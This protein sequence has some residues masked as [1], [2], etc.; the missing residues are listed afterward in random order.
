MLSLQ[1]K[2]P[3]RCANETRELLVS[4]HL[5]TVSDT[6]PGSEPVHITQKRVLLVFLRFYL[7][8]PLSRFFFQQFLLCRILFFGSCQFP[9]PPSTRPQTTSKNNDPSLIYY[10][11][12][13]GWNDDVTGEEFKR[14]ILHQFKGEH[15]CFMFYFLFLSRVSDRETLLVKSLGRSICDSKKHVLLC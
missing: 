3:N 7:M 9:P 5:S 13:P 8:A 15:C 4:F 12:R 1:Y 11:P 2:Y 14:T 10:P 6:P